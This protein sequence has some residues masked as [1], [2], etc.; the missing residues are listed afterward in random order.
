MIKKIFSA[1]VVVLFA[2]SM[3]AQTGL[4][5]EDAIPVDSN[6]VGTIPVA[7]TYWFTVGTY[8]LPLVVHFSP[9]SND[10]KISPEILVDLTCT[11]GVYDDPKVDSLIHLVEAFDLSFPLE[12]LCDLE[13]RNGKNEWD[14]S[15]NDTYR[16]QLT[17]FG[18]NYNVQAFV[19][20]S[21]PEGGEIR[22]K[23]DTLFRNC[24]EE[25]EYVVLDDTLEILPLD[26]ERVFAFP[27]VEWK[28]DSIQFVWNGDSPAQ[29][30]VASTQCDF[31]PNA[32]DSYVF[33][34]F[35]VAADHLY[36]MYPSDLQS[37][38][39]SKAGDGIFYAKIISSS[40]GKLVVEKCPLGAMLGGAKLLEY[41][42]P[43]ELKAND[44]TLYCFPKTWS[45][46]QFVSSSPF[47]T[48]AYFSNTNEFIAEEG[49]ANLLATYTFMTDGTEKALWLSS[50][51]LSVLAQKALDDYI[52]VRFQCAQPTTITP[53]MWAASDCADQSTLIISGVSQSIKAKS[54]NTIYRLRYED[55]KGYDLTINWTGN[56]TL[57]T[58]IADTC[59]FFLSSSESE[60]VYYANIKKKGS[61]DIKVNVVDSWA[62]RVDAD[63]FLYVRFNPN[64]AGKVTF[65]SSKPA[66]Q[67]P[68]IP[69][70][71]CVTNS[72]ELKLSSIVTLNLASVHTIYRINYAEWQAAGAT[73]AW[74][75]TSPLH[76]F[77][78]GTCTFPVAPH[79]R[80]VLDYEA[81]LPAGE[82]VM[83]ADWL[84][85]MAQYVD[86]DGYLYIRFLTEFE[87][88]LRVK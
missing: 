45:S 56:S 84:A 57:P 62:G 17:K 31:T 81:V 21:F 47:I 87:G 41:N 5:C 70:N 58:Y 71:P 78:A 65:V 18:V 68:V 75:G 55:W 48:K 66:E 15:I 76:T 29:V 16:N 13:V 59:A 3:M 43:V 35:E 64:N 28:N 20:V 86:E 34:N 33:D 61:V 38:I 51:E 88:T 74:E 1:L 14:I 11:P 73:L 6:Y 79:N 67:D 40:P 46:T 9:N 36:K 72:T 54:A 52:Y 42:K 30:W 60:V 53:Y 23:P 44:N 50:S 69:T 82:K 22:I 25:S 7:G 19:C 77:L 26:E 63:G 37:V 83:A 85:R 80:Y 2:T 24:M 27:Y 4:T 10:S 8:D 32:S 39:D 49:N 12:F